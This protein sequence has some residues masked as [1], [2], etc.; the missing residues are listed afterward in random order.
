MIAMIRNLLSMFALATLV[1]CRG[2]AAPPEFLAATTQLLEIAA[3]GDSATV[4]NIA[5]NDTTAVRARSLMRREPQFLEA[6][7]RG[8]RPL[9]PATI[10][11]DSARVTY[12]FQ[13]RSRPEELT[14]HLV[15]SGKQWKVSY[16][17]FPAR[18]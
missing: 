12:G 6:F 3:I 16:F 5:A 7:Q 10:Y 1:A 18:M 8:A 4:S 2:P 14:V 15:S 11:G 17:G 9:G 13:Y